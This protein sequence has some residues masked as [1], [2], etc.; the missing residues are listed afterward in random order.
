[1]RRWS[2]LCFVLL[3]SACASH[4]APA[5]AAAGRSAAASAPSTDATPSLISPEE[6]AG[7]WVEYWALTGHADTQRY[8]FY[9]DGRF[10]WLAADG[11]ATP[12]AGRWGQFKITARANE[13]ALELLVQGH[14]ERFG[15]EGMATRR[16][17][18]D[19]AIRDR[20]VLGECP[21]NE[22]AKA[23]D[24]SYRCLAISGRAFWRKMAAPADASPFIPANAK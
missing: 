15:C 20:L 24:P 19:P 23:L 22:E 10:G 16:I 6:L 1:M 13:T 17:L 14:D 21:P 7:V 9:P 12:M 3:L 11:G 5:P 4:P 2:A 8:A 18:H